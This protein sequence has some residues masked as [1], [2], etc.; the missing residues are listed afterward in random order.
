MIEILA[1]NA[2][3]NVEPV[4]LDSE[5]KCR[6]EFKNS[7]NKKHINFLIKEFDNAIVTIGAAL[8]LYIID[9]LKY[10]PGFNN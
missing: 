8:E 1:P 6:S 10:H 2:T 7:L 4:A 9:F 5:R 3:D